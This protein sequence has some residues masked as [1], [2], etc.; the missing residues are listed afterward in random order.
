MLLSECDALLHITS[1]ISSAAIAWNINTCQKRIEIDNGTN[2]NNVFLAQILWYIKKSLPT[3][4]GGF[5]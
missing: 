2:T 4:L 3:F 1:N 5:N